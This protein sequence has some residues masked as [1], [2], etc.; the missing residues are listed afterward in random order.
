[1]TMCVCILAFVIRH[2]MRIFSAQHYIVIC[3][4]SRSTVFPALSHKRHDFRKT[5]LNTKRVV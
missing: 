4:M 3:G 2:A 5:A 1:M